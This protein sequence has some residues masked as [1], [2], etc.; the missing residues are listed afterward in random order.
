MTIVND[1][2]ACTKTWKSTRTS[3]RRTRERMANTLSVIVIRGVCSPGDR[4]TEK[5]GNIA[6]ARDTG[7]RVRFERVCGANRRRRRAS[8]E[9]EEAFGGFE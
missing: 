8:V 7:R 6:D 1:E 9:L 3:L 2:P 5:R 4:W